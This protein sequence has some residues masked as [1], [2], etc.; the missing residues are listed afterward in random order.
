VKSIAGLVVVF[1]FVRGGLPIFLRLVWMVLP[2]TDFQTARMIGA[3][4]TGLKGIVALVAVILFFVWSHRLVSV[5]RARGEA[6][7]YSPAM[8]VGCWFIPFAN[9]AM[10]ALAMADAWRRAVRTGA[11]LV[12]GWW[13]AYVSFII[14]DAVVTNVPFHDR[15]TAT[16]LSW[17][18]TLAS[19]GAYSLWAVMVLKMTQAL[20][21]APARSQ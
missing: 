6:T 2:R 13:A 9:L 20:V 16:A 15:V 3:A 7:S 12:W 11:G 8:T 14:I 17:L 19:A 21:G 1:L 4:T 5:L 10:P 18:D